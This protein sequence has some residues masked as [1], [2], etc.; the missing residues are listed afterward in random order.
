MLAPIMF[1]NSYLKALLFQVNRY[2][3][4]VWWWCSA[5]TFW[6]LWLFPR[7]RY[8]SAGPAVPLNFLVTLTPPSCCCC[9]VSS[10]LFTSALVSV[11]GVSGESRG[12]VPTKELSNQHRRP[13]LPRGVPLGVEALPQSAP[14]GGES[15][16]QWVSPASASPEPS[17]TPET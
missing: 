11:C 6:C 17:R 14:R 13:V 1:L 7:S 8:R 3:P 5:L 15:D 10:V 4:F 16:S 12:L 2:S 9:R